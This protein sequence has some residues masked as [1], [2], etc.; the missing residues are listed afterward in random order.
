[1]V[2]GGIMGTMR[3][4]DFAVENDMVEVAG[5]RVARQAP[6]D[7]LAEVRRR[8]TLAREVAELQRTEVLSLPRRFLSPEQIEAAERAYREDLQEGHA[9][10]ELGS[11]QRTRAHNLPGR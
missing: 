2:G 10:N 7:P 5:H 3:R 1:M 6:V 8:A 4:D 11:S 9:A